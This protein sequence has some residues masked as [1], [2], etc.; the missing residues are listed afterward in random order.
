MEN[1]SPCVVILRPRTGNSILR[2]GHVAA[3]DRIALSGST[4]NNNI[5]TVVSATYDVYSDTTVVVVAEEIA[6]ATADGSFIK[7][8]DFGI[9][10]GPLGLQSNDAG[11]FAGIV[12]RHRTGYEIVHA[13][14]A[15]RR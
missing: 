15:D 6:D 8:M 7:T 2:N 13:G 9:N 3:G 14:S 4:G 11:D 1:R 5:Y 10:L 12:S